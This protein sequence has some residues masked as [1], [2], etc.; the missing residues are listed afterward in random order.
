MRKRSAIHA[1]AFYLATG[2]M[3]GRA[4]TIISGNLFFTTFQ[5][6]SG[7]VLPLTPDLWKVAFVYDSLAGL[8]LGSSTL[9]CPAGDPTITPIATL[10]GADG[11][12]FD[13]NDTTFSTLLVG[14]QDTNRVAQIKT[15]GTGL[16]EKKAD[17]SQP[18]AFGSG[19]AYGVAATPDKT[20]LLTIPNSVGSGQFN[21]N[22]SPLN[23]LGDGTTHAVS[24]PD[25][26]IRGIAFIGNTAYYGDALDFGFTGHVGTI[27]ISGA[28]F[29]TSRSTIVDD[30]NPG[31][32][33]GQGSL[34][35]HG[36]EFDAFSGCIILSGSNQI[37]QVCPDAV[38]ANTLHIK[39]KLST[40]LT[41]THPA[42]NPFCGS[43]NW[44]QVSVDGAG[45]LFAAN[46]DGDLLFIDYSH[47]A[48]KSISDAGNYSKLQFLSVALDDV[49]NGG[50]APTPP[51]G[52]PATQGFWHKASNWPNVA[53]P[54][55][56]D[57]VTYNP[58]HS[59]TIG[60]MTYTQSQLLL[61]LPSGSLHTGGYVNALSQFIAA[62]LNV[63]AGAQHS[64][65]DA[66][67]SAINTDLTGVQFILATSLGSVPP[68]VQAELNA[69]E[70]VLDQYNSAVGLNCTEGTGLNIP[71]R[72]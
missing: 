25:T 47:S 8:C 14:E 39:A 18:D 63:A 66:T 58:N 55:N 68:N 26:S 7:T 38:L 27:D 16:S 13:P 6:Q 56:I 15:D 72:K 29:I 12:I 31:S 53:S 20:K 42:N 30:V 71:S 51:T 59:M 44:D 52:C 65:I 41:C 9:P 34:P 67:I 23:P 24:G 57:G 62:V 36:L 43:V 60:G 54:V 50:G 37:W 49:V 10:K 46:N 4:A 11:L 3:V 70:P 28:T 48:S 35:S 5:N 33:A 61:I 64:T 69:F 2:L 40:I 17:A 22:V 45:H 21:V 32:P 19:Q 1:A